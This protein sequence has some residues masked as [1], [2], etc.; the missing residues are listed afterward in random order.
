MKLLVRLSL[1]MLS[2]ILV[3][4]LA[5]VV[6]MTVIDRLKHEDDRVSA[7]SS[8]IDA[9]RET[10]IK[11]ADQESVLDA[12]IAGADEPLKA[13]FLGP[14]W[15]A[16]DQ[17]IETARQ[18]ARAMN[19]APADLEILAALVQDWRKNAEIDMTVFMR[20]QNTQTARMKVRRHLNAIITTQRA[21][22]ATAQNSKSDAMTVIL[23]T[24]A[25]GTFAAVAVGI[26]AT[27]WF[28][29]TIQKPMVRLNAAVNALRRN[30]FDQPIDDT[31]RKDEIGAIARAIETFK[32]S[33]LQA[34]DM[35]TEQEE[36]KKTAQLDKQD[37]IA[38]ISN[39]FESSVK[40]VAKSVAATAVTLK[41]ASDE[42]SAAATVA[43]E[44]AKESNDAATVTANIVQ[45]VAA[46][47]EQLSCSIERINQQV[48][49]STETKDRAVV[50]SEK[51]HLHLNRLIR[52]SE[53]IGSV[54]H[55]IK[56][57][58]HQTNLLALNATIEAQR[59]GEAGKGFAVVAGEVRTLAQQT[60]NAAAGISN[61]IAEVQSAARDSTDA[62]ETVSL[63][64]NHIDEI[65]K[66]IAMAIEQQSLATR[67]ISENV[68][69]A[70][71]NSVRQSE[72]MGGV[73][74]ATQKTIAYAQNLLV[75]MDS[76]QEKSDDLAQDV[77]RFLSKIRA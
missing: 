21:N 43:G 36:M 6:N 68:Q 61:L 33:L 13:Q 65:T 76:L 50:A 12:Y 49:E 73:M 29:F 57:V 28:L 67:E 10:E 64:I 72:L 52:E 77:D 27:V 56:A 66:S 32:I 75:S 7:Y 19:E 63:T 42:M 1:G 38:R 23:V 54:L 34:Q 22:I 62:V 37:A 70:A 58:A 69:I 20:Q 48:I 39:D 9:L 17:A 18:H 60:G 35:R 8:I 25:A 3:V 47:T 26:T 2:V 40:G 51:T 74:D 4:C 30:A 45:T 41:T 24:G 55:M 44:M 15:H 59:A 16:V 31:G 11:L 53:K 71:T 14:A 46:A 5:C